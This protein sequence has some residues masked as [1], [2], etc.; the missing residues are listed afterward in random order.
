MDISSSFCSLCAKTETS[1][2]ENFLQAW[3]EQ[4]PFL[5]KKGWEEEKDGKKQ[6]RVYSFFLLLNVGFLLLWSYCSKKYCLFLRFNSAFGE[7][8]FP[9]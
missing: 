2:N 6:L 5:Q 7:L 4:F 3:G 1:V 8:Y 9:R